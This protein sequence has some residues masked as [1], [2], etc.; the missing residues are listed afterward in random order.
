M[1]AR[2][3]ARTRFAF[4]QGLTL[5]T[6]F[7][8][9]AAIHGDRHLVHEHDTGVQLTYA[10]AA[11]RVDRW[12]GA[13]AAE[14]EPGDRVV[15]ATPN[16]YE[17]LLLCLAA[18]RAGGLAVPVNPQMRS[19]EVEH[20]IRDAG[21]AM[22]IESVHQVDDAQP[23]G[24]AVER[25]P[26]AVAALFYT[27]GT[28]GKPKGAELT[29]DALVGQL[30]TGALWP[31]DLRR[32]EAVVG[33]P[34]PH[35]MGFVVLLGL[36]VAGI[37]VYMLPR[38]RPTDVLDAIESRRSTVFIGVPAMYRMLLEAGAEDRDLRSV[39]L[40]G[41]GA[42]VMP[43]D[44]IKRFQRMGAIGRVPVLGLDVGQAAFMEG[45]GM[46]ELAGGAAAKLWPPFLA[47][48]PGDALGLALP[49]YQMKVVDAHGHQVPPGVVGELWVKGP[50]VLKGYHNDPEATDAVVTPDGW[51]RTGD[52]ARRGPM[53][54]VLFAG[55]KKDVI[56]HGGYS[57]YAVEVE[58]ALEDHPEVLEAGVTGLPDDR[59]GE[60]PVAAV[61]VAEGSRLTP[62]GLR[63]WVAE[64]LADYKVPQR[65]VF[66]DDLP[67]TGTQKVQRQE[68]LSLFG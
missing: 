17:L 30:R 11:R 59:M 49:R 24:R 55:R 22:V 68:L 63:A 40:W 13:I 45:Y 4:R 32:D 39:R 58:A 29:H 64:R 33:L 9:L 48:V 52:L 19:H 61:R 25:H 65:V 1:I 18:A 38:F 47:L 3:I 23:L 10:Q 6:V 12:A 26:G 37:P 14:I 27:S 60:L 53:G 8:E 7:E 21:A 35:I 51:L 42:D 31:S 43:P 54:S 2:A 41:S 62:D 56:K 57:V 16:G 20:V 50:G 34:V 46:V 36:A 28:T 66:V 5:G 15:V 44:L 67:R